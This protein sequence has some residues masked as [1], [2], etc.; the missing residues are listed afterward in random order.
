MKI[1][2][3]VEINRPPDVV[4]PVLLDVE[5]WPEWT[6]SMTE[7]ERMDQSA[8]GVGCSLR[9][10]QPR[11]KT[12]VWRVAELQE[13]RLLTWE[14]RG[15]GVSIAARHAVRASERGSIVKLTIDQTGWMSPL[16]TLF[17]GRLTR[18]YVEMEAQGLKQQCEALTRWSDSE[19]IPVKP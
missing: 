2:V 6:A 9:I 16:L 7:I 18:R 11:L 13:G 5:R 3:S 8:I 12:M 10:R 19:V 17:L 1:E 4:W 15:V 14:T